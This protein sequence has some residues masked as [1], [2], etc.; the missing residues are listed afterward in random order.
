MAC[1]VCALICPVGT[2]QV[3]THE[4]TGEVEISPFKARAK[5]RVCE[6]CGARMVS[7]PVAEA[8]LSKAKTQW[9]AL[10]RQS[11]LCPACRRRR[12]TAALG[13]VAGKQK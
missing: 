8:V 9:D 2:I 4:D 11:R 10:R 1:G 13:P 3:R 7:E 6:E 12:T 5:Q